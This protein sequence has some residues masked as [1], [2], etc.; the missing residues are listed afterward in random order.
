[1]KLQPGAL[2]LSSAVTFAVIW[3]VCSLLVTLLPGMMMG[4]TGDMIHADMDQMSWS[5]N[6]GGFVVGLVIWSLLAGV[7][8]W[9]IAI[10]YNRFSSET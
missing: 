1:M 3:I 4:M 5:M 7:T 8:G 10:F 6:F 9:L 2:A